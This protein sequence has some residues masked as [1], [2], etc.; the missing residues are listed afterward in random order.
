VFWY[1]YGDNVF[2]ARK[3]LNEVVAEITSKNLG[4]KF[5]KIYKKGFDE[6]ELKRIVENPSLFGQK[7]GFL[8]EEY[9]SFTPKQKKDITN[10]FSRSEALV[11]FWDSKETR[12]ATGLKKSFP[13]INILNFP[14]PKIIFSFM[15]TVFPGNQKQFL[16]LFAKIISDQPIELVLYFLKQHFRT[17]VMF[18]IDKNLISNL[19]SWREK[20]LEYQSERFP[21]KELENLYKNLIDIEYQNKSG[22]LPVGLEIALVNLLAT[23]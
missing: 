11:I 21:G 9:N 10:I 6:N 1:I 23:V 16:P 7:N 8:I 2:S 19:P 15:E 12:L 18:S 22:I 4:L 14:K 5:V 17:L 20:K 13:K 3:K